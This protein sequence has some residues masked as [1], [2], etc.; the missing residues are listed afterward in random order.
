M[1]FV[2]TTAGQTLIDA[3]P[4]GLV[5]CTSFRVAQTVSYI[6]TPS[7]TTANGSML[8]SG[9][10]SIPA[11]QQ[12]G[13]VKY[14]M[15]IDS[16]VGNFA[17]NEVSLWVGNTLFAIACSSSDIQKV[18]NTGIVQGNSLTITGYVTSGSSNGIIGASNS[19]TEYNVANVS[20]PDLLPQAATSDINIYQVGVGS[21][22]ELS[23]AHK[24]DNRWELTGYASSGPLTIAAGGANYV[25]FITRQK[26]VTGSGYM[27]VQ[28][29]SGANAGFVRTVS[30]Y[31]DGTIRYNLA[32]AFP[33][34][35]EA[36][37]QVEILWYNKIDDVSPVIGSGAPVLGTTKTDS[38]YYIDISGEYPTEYAYD[39]ST[40]RWIKLGVERRV[41]IGMYRNR[42]AL[43]GNHGYKTRTSTSAAVNQDSSFAWANAFLGGTL[44]VTGVFGDAE[45]TLLQDMAATHVPAALATDCDFV[46]IVIGF[47][48]IY[49]GQLSATAA[50]TYVDSIINA[51]KAA[52]KIPIV[53]SIRARSFV[54]E[55]ITS[56]HL[57]FNYLLRN[58]LRANS[59][60]VFVDA[61]RAS[62][63]IDDA[64]GIAYSG[65]TADGIKL[66]QMGAKY[67]GKAKAAALKPF[68][69]DSDYEFSFAGDTYT[70][71]GS[72]NVVSNSSFS[73]TSGTNST[74]VTGT[75]IPTDWRV[76][77]VT[78][79][80][81]GVARVQM[82]EIIDPK[83]GLV[84]TNGLVISIASGT[85]AAGDKLRVV[86]NSST[87]YSRIQGGNFIRGTG[88]VELY[89][90]ATGIARVQLNIGANTAVTSWGAVAN[91][92]GTYDDLE[93]KFVASTLP[94]Q[95]DGSGAASSGK[96]ELE[97]Y[98][99]GGQTPA[100]ITVSSIKAVIT[101]TNPFI[102][103]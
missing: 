4:G 25:Q 69:M 57:K 67:I 15:F 54:S 27:L 97:I 86:Q 80:G 93:T 14:D 58:Y 46:D 5:T 73:G 24:I 38:G 87:F 64:N 74:N 94:V 83:T 2:L 51:I 81:T 6:P 53:S 98:F 91:G 70:R 102:N 19:S 61:F 76:E 78:R 75:S 88:Y 41:D 8:F 47:A 28:A 21:S 85:P 103:A 45:G 17:F 59:Q 100:V 10:P 16:T 26:T 31:I 1:I 56:E 43:V 84:S 18:K 40:P 55:A 66:S 44:T 34:V 11:A 3:A 71:V 9:I 30:S 89:A 12:N 82:S 62:V 39:K 65:F 68:V 36:N 7:Q 60:V 92:A 29:L 50:M 23:L 33:S 35:L 79:T 101:Q 95:V 42:V 90:A 72:N 96:A 20:V 52:K 48:D 22:G 13:S 32:N 99:S 63:D 37:A 49:G 77:W